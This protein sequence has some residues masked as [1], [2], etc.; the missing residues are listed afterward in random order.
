MREWAERAR[1]APALL[2]AAEAFVSVGALWE[3]DAD[4]AHAARA[5]AAAHL[6]AAGEPSL[7][8][9][10][11]LGMAELLTERFAD[12]CATATRGLEIVQRTGH[13]QLLVP[14]SC[15][16]ALSQIERLDLDSAA[17]YADDAA[18]SARLQDM[19]HLQE[20]VLLTRLPLHELRGEWSD[21]SQALEEVAELLPRLPDGFA[22]RSLRATAATLLAER[23][24]ERCMRELEPLLEPDVVQ[25]SRLLLVLVRCA[26]AARPPR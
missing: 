7:E 25:T 15:V 26:L 3:G 21:A 2:G 24:P 6:R 1:T 20:L 13:A 10:L 17:R 22:V 8:A 11:S 18:E 4:T 12:A 5:R 19:P 16:A 23:D 9:L 14:L